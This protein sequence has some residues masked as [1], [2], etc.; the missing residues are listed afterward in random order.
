MAIGNGAR[1]GRSIGT[2]VSSITEDLSTLVRGEIALA[3]AEMAASAKSAARG[4]ALLAGRARLGF[5]TCERLQ[6]WRG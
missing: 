5:E 1:E 6:G 4:A 2:L 3:K